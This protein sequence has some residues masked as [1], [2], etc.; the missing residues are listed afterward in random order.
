[1]ADLEQPWTTPICQT[2][3]TIFIPCGI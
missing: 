2:S 1:M 3:V